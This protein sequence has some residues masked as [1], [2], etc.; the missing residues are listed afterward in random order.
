MDYTNDTS[1]IMDKVLYGFSEDTI[2]LSDTFRIASFLET[3]NHF[4]NKIN[5]NNYTSR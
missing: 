3:T 2:L 5:E 4:L 1:T